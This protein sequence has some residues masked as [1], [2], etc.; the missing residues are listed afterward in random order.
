MNYDINQKE[1]P[2]TINDIEAPSGWEWT[3]SQWI[4]DLQGA[5]NHDG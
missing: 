2:L 3:S 5:V 4:V 1:I